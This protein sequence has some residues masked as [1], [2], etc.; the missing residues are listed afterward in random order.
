MLFRKSNILAFNSLI[1]E[2]DKHVKETYEGKNY[3]CC[4]SVGY[5]CPGFTKTYKLTSGGFIILVK[6]NII[7]SEIIKIHTNFSQTKDGIAWNITREADYKRT[8][9]NHDTIFDKSL[10]TNEFCPTLV[11]ERMFKVAKAAVEYA[12]LEQTLMHL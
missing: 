2:W 6:P 11:K 3:D 4:F 7:T 10:L 5:M 8:I 12:K 9:L 1:S